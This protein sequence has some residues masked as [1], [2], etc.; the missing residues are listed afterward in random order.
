MG[1]RRKVSFLYAELVEVG[2]GKGEGLERPHSIS[3]TREET[4]QPIYTLKR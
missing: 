4:L 3:G 1:S 2:F